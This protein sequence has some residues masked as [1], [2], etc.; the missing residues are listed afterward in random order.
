MRFIPTNSPPKWK[1]AK[2]PLSASWKSKR[3][4]RR[5]S[6]ATSSSS[7][8]KRQ[9]QLVKSATAHALF[10]LFAL[11]ISTPRCSAESFSITDDY[12]AYLKQTTN[13]HDFGLKPDERF[14]PYST[15]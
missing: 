7:A 8:F 1:R 12:F 15:P 13:P 10:I 2:G 5:F 14:Y 6:A 9:G 3:W 11:A 4:V